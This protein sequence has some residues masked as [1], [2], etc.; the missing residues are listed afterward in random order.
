M[1]PPPWEPKGENL[2]QTQNL[3]AALE[4]QPF[5]DFKAKKVFK[6]T[7]A[8]K[9]ESLELPPLTF[10]DAHQREGIKWILSRS[11]SYLAHAPGAGKTCQAIVASQLIQQMGHILFIVPPTLSMN[12]VKEVKHFCQLMG[13]YPIV[14]TVPPTPNQDEMNWRADIVI[15]PDSMLAKHWVYKNLLKL[16]FKFIAVDEASRFKEH[17][18]RRSKAFYGGK[19]GEIQYPGLFQGSPYTVLLDGSPMP[20]RPLELWTPTYAL[21]PVSIDC[22]DFS[23]FAFRYC[24]ARLNDRGQWEFRGATNL[25]ELNR[26]ITKNFMHVVKEEELS[27]P[28]RLRSIL[29]MTEDIRTPK[30]KE[31]EKKNLGK[32]RLNDLKEGAE[33]GHLAEHRWELGI[34][35]VRWVADYVR[36]RLKEKNEAILLF[37]WHREVCEELADS[38]K[39]FEPSIVYGGTKNEDR[40]KA[41]SDFQGGI[42]KLLIGNIQA[43]GRGHNLQRASRIIFA[44][45]SWSDELNKQCEKR[46]SRRGSKK[47]FVRCEYVCVPDSLDEV[48]LQTI[49]RKEKI[50]KRVVK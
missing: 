25:E 5:S 46:A 32:L 44:E 17:N 3:K 28:E 12:W 15:C 35:K 29:F 8:I 26:K 48:V 4:F 41:F 19:H 1:A 39:E 22:M 31:W 7:L 24:G 34:R 49:F 20:N 38:L 18:S 43:C 11:R 14:A 27:H 13:I 6:R 16:K 42:R 40:E 9:Y 23:D 50:V 30:M 37:C 45:Y 36:D 21:D 2:F 33:R 10:L 47:S